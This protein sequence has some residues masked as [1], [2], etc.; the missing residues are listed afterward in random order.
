MENFRDPNF[1]LVAEVLYWL[2]TRVDPECNIS[3]DI[4]GE[5]Q[6][7]KFVTSITSFFLSKMRIKLNMKKV[8]QA[9]G[10]SVKELLKI[11]GMLSKAQS[12]SNQDDEETSKF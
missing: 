5:R 1:E 6:R 3:D 11:A 9:D 4:D 8:Y 12:T 10:Y 7:I 2:A